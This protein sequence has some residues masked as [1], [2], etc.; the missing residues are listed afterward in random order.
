MVDKF[1]VCFPRELEICRKYYISGEK[2]LFSEVVKT[3]ENIEKALE[4]P[5]D[6]ITLESNKELR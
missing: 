5:V 3:K 4:Y 6:V 2:I 1:E